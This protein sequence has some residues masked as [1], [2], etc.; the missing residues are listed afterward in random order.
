MYGKN[1]YSNKQSIPNFQV[2]SAYL[3]AYTYLDEHNISTL[4]GTDYKVTVRYL[5]TTHNLPV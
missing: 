4:T 3:A 1:C 2:R 5:T